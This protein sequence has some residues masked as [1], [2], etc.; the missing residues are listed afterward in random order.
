MLCLCE[1]NKGFLLL[2]SQNEEKHTMLQF[3]NHTVLKQLSSSWHFKSHITKQN[4]GYE[5]PEK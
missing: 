5:M 1:E 4:T 3:N 2:R